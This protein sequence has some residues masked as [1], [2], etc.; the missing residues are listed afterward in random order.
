MCYSRFVVVDMMIRYELIIIFTYYPP[1]PPICVWVGG[2]RNKP[3]ISVSVSLVTHT[4]YLVHV[5]LVCIA[6][7]WALKVDHHPSLPVLSSLLVC[8]SA[9]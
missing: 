1:P 5:Y 2:L 9:L 8:L 3:C 6:L 7:D 4:F